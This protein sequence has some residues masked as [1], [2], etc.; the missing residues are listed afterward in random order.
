MDSPY[1]NEYSIF[2]PVEVTIR[3]RLMYKE[4]K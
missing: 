3:R 2:K 1:K 4:E